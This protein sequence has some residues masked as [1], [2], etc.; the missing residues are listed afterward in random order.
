MSSKQ[1]FDEY[2]RQINQRVVNLQ[3]SYAELAE[4]RQAQ[5]ADMI[6]NS[7]NERSAIENELQKFIDGNN[8]GN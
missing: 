2:M 3:A 4:Q 7:L 1:T 6:K 8:G 5:V